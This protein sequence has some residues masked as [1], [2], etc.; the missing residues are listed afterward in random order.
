MSFC[1]SNGDGIGD[2]P[3]I[4]SKLDY[5]HDLGIDVIWLSPI[6]SSP[7]KDM[8]YDISDYQALDPRYGTM[9]D[10]DALLEGLR[11]RGMKLMMD[12]VVNHT[13]D[14]VRSIARKLQFFL[15]LMSS[16]CSNHSTSGLLNLENQKK[17]PNETGISGDPRN[18]MS[19]V[20]ANRLTTGPR[21]GA[22]IP[23]LIV[24]RSVEC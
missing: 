14:L 7:N 24:P 18:T 9:E 3:G 21:V 19:T 12:L 20:N 2:V 22:V 23:A 6:Y 4:I 15:V 16:V 10:M 17:A 8:G 11:E 5:L 1:D 13:S